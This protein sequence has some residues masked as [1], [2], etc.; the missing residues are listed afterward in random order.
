MLVLPH[1]DGGLEPPAIVALE[2][3]APLFGLGTA[4]G[5]RVGGQVRHF[6]LRLEMGTAALVARQGSLDDGLGQR[7][8]VEQRPREHDVLIGPVAAVGQGTL[9]GPLRQF[10]DFAQRVLQLLVAADDGGGL[11]HDIPQ[12]LVQ[13]I[14][15][16]ATRRPLEQILVRLLVPP[17]LPLKQR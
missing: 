7:E 16:L 14:R 5:R 11:G 4:F 6:E 8:H 12:R 10:L 15:I 3:V 1:R 2:A 13:Q 9:L 17:G